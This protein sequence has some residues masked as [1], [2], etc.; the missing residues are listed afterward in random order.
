VDKSSVKL[1]TQIN[2]SEAGERRARQL[3]LGLFA[4]IAAVLAAG[5]ILVLRKPS[6]VFFAPQVSADVIYLLIWLG[7][8]AL[9]ALATL[10]R[11]WLPVSFGVLLFLAAEGGSQ[12]YLYKTTGTLHRAAPAVYFA[13]FE[14]HPLLVGIPREGNYAG[15]VH[16][17]QHRR[18]TW[19]EGKAAGSKYIYAFGG[20]TTYDLANEDL[21]TWPSDLSRLL[22]NN[23]AIENYGVPG[24]TSL[25][26]MI[27]SLFA[28]REHK[29]VCAVYFE[30]IND[31]RNAHI[32]NLRAD[33][34]NFHL[35][36]Q[37]GGLGLDSKPGLLTNYSA[38]ISLLVSF[39][40]VHSQEGDP[41]EGEASDQPDQHLDAIYAENLNLIAEI[42]RHF[43][44]KVIFVPNMANYGALE[45][46]RFRAW[47]PFVRDKD[48][49]VLLADLGRVMAESAGKSGAIY[50]GWP[51]T[52]EWAPADFVDNVHFS[53]QG[54]EK[55]ARRLS[56]DI[57]ALCD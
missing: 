24:Y 29:P 30:G 20:S 41:I 47:M 36:G 46:G 32:R 34:S 9:G 51:L 55:F 48:I 19:N 22:G 28:F 21:A 15:I 37:R 31:L 5:V 16:D 33:F 1:S 52:Q 23:Y 17:A 35:P 56:K 39:L 14:P 10:R 2:L 40:P 54:A 8:C 44:V 18:R 53:T 12:L 7:L 11:R 49:K 6:Y 26:N 57:A 13:R 43:G 3:V 38:V 27:Q 50:L 25:E 45:T 4:I 42:D